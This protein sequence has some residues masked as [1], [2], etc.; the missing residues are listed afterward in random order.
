MPI[1]KPSAKS[2]LLRVTRQGKTHSTATGF[3]V[4]SGSDDFLVTNY[5]VLSGRRPDTNEF[6]GRYAIGPAE[7]EIF[8]NEAG[9]LGAW[10]IRTEPL[11]GSDGVGLWMEH[12]THG[13]HVDVVALRLT[14]LDAVAIYPHDIWTN[15]PAIQLRVASDLSIIG[16]PFGLTGGGVFGIWSRATVASEPMLDFDDLPRF[17]VDS[18]TRPGQSGRRYCYLVARAKC[19]S[20]AVVRCLE[21]RFTE[22]SECTQAGLTNKTTSGSSG[23]QTQS[24]RSLLRA[25]RRRFEMNPSMLINK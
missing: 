15:D 4:T 6:V 21:E 20:M 7:V 24:E 17:L 2:L 1:D 23:K 5:H 16:F 3:I 25:E 8:H 22:S 9:K 18:R 19:Q 13:R 11:Y 14:Q 12:P 10:R